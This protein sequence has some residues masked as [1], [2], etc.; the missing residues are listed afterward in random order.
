MLSSWLHKHPGNATLW[1]KM[2]KY[3]LENEGQKEA[4]ATC[5]GAAILK[6]HELSGVGTEI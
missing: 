6:S 1:L 5:A 2:A 3:L 4:A